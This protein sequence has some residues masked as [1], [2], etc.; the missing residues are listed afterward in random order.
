MLL[1]RALALLMAMV[2]VIAATPAQAQSTLA[3]SDFH[4]TVYEEVDF[5]AV[6]EAGGTDNRYATGRFTA[7]GQLVTGDVEWGPDDDAL[8]RIRSR[9]NTRINLNGSGLELNPPIPS[10]D[11]STRSGEDVIIEFHRHVGQAAPALPLTPF[12]EPT[13]VA[14]SF[15]AFLSETTPGGP[16]LAQTLIVILVFVALLYKMP[17]TPTG[18]I[19]AAVVLVMTPWIPVL[20]GGLIMVA[21]SAWARRSRAGGSA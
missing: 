7:S 4:Q 12:A 16:A 17:A 13:A 8:I 9:S 18:I 14:G 21:W 10:R 1:A 5:V 19:L 20:F 3:L 6:I 11:W 15:V 2:A